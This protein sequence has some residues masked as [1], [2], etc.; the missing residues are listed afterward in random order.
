MA[1]SLEADGHPGAAGIK[2][3]KPV[4][5]AFP[6]RTLHNTIDCGVFLMRHM[7]TYKGTSVKDWKCEL[8]NERDDKGEVSP[9]QQRELDD[10]RHKYVAKILLNDVNTLKHVVE[11]EINQFD[12]LSKGYKRILENTALDRI[13][14]R[15]DE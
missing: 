9:K 5:L 12:K 7:E 14:K 10:L 4:R 1:A 3:A 6:W 13:P 11:E 8:S 2:A 15:V